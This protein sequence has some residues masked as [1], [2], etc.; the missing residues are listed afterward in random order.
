MQKIAHVKMADSFRRYNCVKRMDR[1]FV[2]LA[3]CFSCFV[4]RTSPFHQTDEPFHCKMLMDDRFRGGL[5]GSVQSRLSMILLSKVR[6]C[7]VVRSALT[8]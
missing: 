2:L 5:V 3:R 8:I 6:C 4:A 7:S 1:I